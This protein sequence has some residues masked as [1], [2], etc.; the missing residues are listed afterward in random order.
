MYRISRAVIAPTVPARTGKGELKTAAAK[1][2]A[3]D[4][5][6]TGPVEHQECQDT[7]REGRLPADVPHAT[8]VALALFSD[9]GDE[10]QS[11]VAIFDR[12]RR[13][14][15]ARHRQPR[16]PARAILGDPRAAA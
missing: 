7:A 2:L 12:R 8:Q 6:G 9:I 3:G 11:G 4:V 10:D 13:F 15:S 1:R 16:R 14:E 5:L